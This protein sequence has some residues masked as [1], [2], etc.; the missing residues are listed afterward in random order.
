MKIDFVIA[1]IYCI[2]LPLVALAAAGKASHSLEAYFLGN[3]RFGALMM[4][5]SGMTDWFDLSGTMLITS[6]L[7]LMGPR[8]LYVEFR[9]GAVLILAFLMLWTGKWHRRSGCMTAAEWITFR[10]GEGVSADALR[11]AI[12][13]FNVL[14]GIGM[15][16]YIVRGTEI[17]F[18]SFVPWSPTF[19]TFC[20]IGVT[21]LYT[22]VSGFYGVTLTNFIHGIVIM[23]A[24]LLVGFIGW[25]AVGKSGFN[26]SMATGITGVEDWMSALPSFQVQGLPPGYENF[27]MLA[28][29]TL[30]CLLRVTL[31]GMG[32]G[33]EPRFFAARDD[34]ACGVQTL[35]QGVTIALRWVMMAGFVVLGLLWFREQNAIGPES[36]GLTTESFAEHVIPVVL[37]D[38]LPPFVRGIVLIALLGAMMSTLSC[39]LNSSAAT[40][41]RDIYQHIFRPRAGRR[42]LMAASY[43]VSLVLAAAG[44]WAGVCAPDLNCL[45]GWLSMGLMVGCCGPMFLRLYWWRCNACGCVTGIICGTSAA[46]VYRCLHIAWNDGWSFVLAATFS[47]AGTLAG[48]L[49]SAPVPGQVTVNFFRVTRPFGFWGE[50]S[51]VLSDDERREHRR[52]ISAV[53]FVMTAQ[54]S[55][56]IFAM[57]IVLHDYRGALLSGVVCLLSSAF[58]WRLWGRYQ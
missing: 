41:V 57:Q 10:F 1:I 28:G 6:F 53:P 33:N 2:I 45:W 34:R 14:I 25:T 15:L 23:T 31:G 3:R 13:V 52:D 56:F 48:S 5:I 8:G 42:E 22:T 16:S 27:R 26:G 29:F 38:S 12:A 51:R 44:S 7:F 11:T 55:L 47:F 54:I 32:M 46:I 49:L 9:G 24:C 17:F 36:D 58:V 18:S 50:Y 4:G 40:F 20:V 19:V 35:L 21:V 30:L 43:S 39:F 37:R